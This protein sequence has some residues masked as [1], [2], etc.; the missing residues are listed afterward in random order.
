MNEETIKSGT[1]HFSV[2][3]LLE[4]SKFFIF[5]FLGRVV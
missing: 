3:T 4:F 1:E 5:L 2:D